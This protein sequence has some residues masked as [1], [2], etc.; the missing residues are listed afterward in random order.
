MNHDPGTLMD[1]FEGNVM[2]AAMQ[3]TIHGSHAMETYF[4]N[5]LSGLDTANLQTQQTVPFLLQ[6]F[7]R[8][9]NFIGN[10]LGTS[11]YHNTYQANFGGSASNCNTSIYNLG[12]GGVICAVST[13]NNDS[14]VVS[15]LMRWGN[16]DVVNASA[17]WNA[18]E[19][20]SGL[21]IYANAVPSTHS[22]PS[23]FYLSGKPSF[24]PSSK[25]F[26]GIGPDIT[27]GNIA[28][29]GGHAYTIPAEDCYV[30]VMGGSIT[31]EVGVL[32]F[33]AKNCYGQ[34]TSTI[35]PPTNL[36]VVSIN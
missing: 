27:G 2:P 32:T 34:T 18:A 13:V 4:R 9:A 26:P 30:S 35:A 23:S 31:S 24:W 15:T 11:G 10:V 16:Y 21:S 8:Y 3:D 14:L 28:N 19:V 7:S 22:L 33:N 29:A 17:Q 1:L 36:K 20:P 6:S 25:P 12:W 5:R